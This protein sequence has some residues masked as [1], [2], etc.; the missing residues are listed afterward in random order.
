LTYSHIYI[1]ILYDE[2]R[3]FEIFRNYSDFIKKGS[4]CMIMKNFKKNELKEGAG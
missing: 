1:I 2:S 3:T 4:G